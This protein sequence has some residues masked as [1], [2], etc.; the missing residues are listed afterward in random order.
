MGGSGQVCCKVHRGP[1]QEV[2]AGAGAAWGGSRWPMLLPTTPAG[3]PPVRQAP[4]PE[5]GTDAS[6]SCA[7]TLGPGHIVRLSFPGGPGGRAQGVGWRAGAP[8]LVPAH[9]LCLPL[10][11]W[12]GV[13]HHTSLEWEGGWAPRPALGGCTSL[14]NHLCPLAPFPAV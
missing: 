10:P 6:K 5:Q 14:G 8:G 1:G 7:S 12:V 9:L 2:A 11:L 4:R 3:S 13:E